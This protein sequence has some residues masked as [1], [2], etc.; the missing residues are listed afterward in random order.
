[1][2]RL[3]NQK[4]LAAAAEAFAKTNASVGAV[5]LVGS[6]ARGEHTQES[7]IDLLVRA[8]KSVN[9]SQDD[10]KA[11][12]RAHLESHGFYVRAVDAFVI[13]D[14]DFG[15]RSP[16]RRSAAHMRFLEASCGV[17]L[18]GEDFRHLLAPPPQQ[19]VL[20][21]V[22][23][24]IAELLDHPEQIDARDVLLIA[25]GRMYA[26][27]GT[28]PSKREA[29]EWDKHPAVRRAW[30]HR[31][32]TEQSTDDSDSYADYV[33]AAARELESFVQ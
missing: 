11:F 5:L 13:D 15:P 2:L 3:P 23:N 32:Q 22:L 16:F 25:M 14:R 21:R 33:R 17:L 31:T 28:W 30:Q 8:T 24:Q 18:W 20:E 10:V 29:A 26:H 7:D 4:D 6:Y 19:T 27:T 12:F 1:L 9:I